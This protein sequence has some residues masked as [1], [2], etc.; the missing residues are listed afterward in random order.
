MLSIFSLTSTGNP[1]NPL[2]PLS[3]ATSIFG[4]PLIAKCDVKLNLLFP[5][6]YLQGVNSIDALVIKMLCLFMPSS[7]AALMIVTVYIM[8]SL[9]AK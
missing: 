2:P 5:D 8:A 3:G 7:P 6:H 9:L 4:R 1:L